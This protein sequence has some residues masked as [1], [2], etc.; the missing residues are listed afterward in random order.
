MLASLLGF[1][2]HDERPRG[3]HQLSRRRRGPRAG[4][5]ARGRAAGGLRRGAGAAG[6]LLPVGRRRRARRRD[7]AAREDLGRP[8]R[9]ARRARRRAPSVRAPRGAGGPSRRRTRP[10]PRLDPLRDPDPRRMIRPLSFL[11]GLLAA[12]WLALAPA[13]AVA[14]VDESDLLPI[15]EAFALQA[16]A[17]GRGRIEFTWTIA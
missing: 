6:L 12:G 4:A 7:R 2:A 10:L 15:D 1:A 17:T 5:I 9:R 13:P 16:R 14:A 11:A 8:R 3:P